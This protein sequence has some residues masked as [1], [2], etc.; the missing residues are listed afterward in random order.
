M[1]LKDF[2]NSINH[3]KKPLLDSEEIG[4]SKYPAFVVNKCMS[5]FNDTIF[6]A[7]EMNCN[8]WIDAKAQFDFYRLGVRKKKRYSPWLEKEEDN[9]IA[10]IKEVFGYSEPKARE[11]LNIISPQDIE[12]LKKSLEKGWVKNLI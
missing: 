4:S 11:V 6:Y 12:K 1:V 5:Y 3:D 9:D 7:N 8:P 10:V 2:L